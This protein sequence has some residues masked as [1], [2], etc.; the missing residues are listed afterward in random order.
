MYR[1][2]KDIPAPWLEYYG[3]T[4]PHLDYPESTMAELMENAAAAWP[5]SIAF[6]FLGRATSYR[7]FAE[8]I[9]RAARAFAALGIRE[10]DRVT[11][12]MPNTPQGVIALYALNMAGA[13]ANM[14][15]PLSSE[16]EIRFFL[17]ESEI[18]FR[19]TFH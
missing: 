1:F 14:I 10:H 15:H 6:D 19:R 18:A 13:V 5:E 12:C 2:V 16:G 3:E 9:R 17:E 11:V 8:E 7:K 4:P